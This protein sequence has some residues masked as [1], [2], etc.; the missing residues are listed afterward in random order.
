V[1]SSFVSESVDPDDDLVVDQTPTDL[2][3]NAWSLRAS[4]P[5]T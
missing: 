4:K 5:T 1:A 3:G 2:F